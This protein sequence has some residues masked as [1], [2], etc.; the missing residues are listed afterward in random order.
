MTQLTTKTTTTY[1]L[2]Q[3][4]SSERHFVSS[5]FRAPDCD[6][7]Y[8]Q[9]KRRR[10]KPQSILTHNTRRKQQWEDIAAVGSFEGAAP[11]G[12]GERAREWR[13]VLKICS[14]QVLCQWPFSWWWSSIHHG[15]LKWLLWWCRRL[16]LW[17]IVFLDLIPFLP[18]Q[19]PWLLN[20]SIKENILFG[21]PYKVS[22]MTEYS[23]RTSDINS[24]N[25]DY[26]RI[27]ISASQ[28]KFA[29]QGIL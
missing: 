2:P 8:E 27:H 28:I 22:R 26:S 12:G 4:S 24:L 17:L 1:F 23:Y 25:F 21:R 14:S 10:R 20:A 19:T 9:R 5:S 3:P 15:C 18:S 29:N 7:R 16:W 11:V 6:S 13:P